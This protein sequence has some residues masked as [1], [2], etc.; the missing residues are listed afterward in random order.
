MRVLIEYQCPQCGAPAEL[1]E[2]DRLFSCQYC[3]VK[4]YLDHQNHFQYVLPDKAPTNKNLFFIPYWRF[5]GMLFSCINKNIE[6]KFVDVSLQAF[7]SI[8]FPVSVGL[9]SQSLKM[10]FVTPDLNGY[11][12]KP[13][14]TF[15]N[16]M[17]TFMNRFTTTPSEMIQHQTHVGETI[18]IIYSPFY[19]DNKLY[20]AVLNETIKTQLP[21]DFDI[22]NF[23]GG[24]PTWSLD[25]I[26]T[27][28]PYCGWDLKGDRDSIALI[29]NNCIS[30]WT[31]IKKKLK[32]INFGCLTIKDNAV[33]FPFWRIK[34]DISGI[35]LKS[36]ADLVKIANLPKAIQKGWDKIDFY[37]WVPGF[38]VRPKTFLRLL[39]QTT[40]AQPMDE[41]SDQLPPNKIFPVNLPS[42]EAAETLK[43]NLA[44]FIKNDTFLD[45]LS[46]IKIKPKDLLLTFIPFEEGHHDYVQPKYQISINK[47]QLILSSNL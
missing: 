17:D 4:S 35:L 37:F 9:R 24:K 7:D 28:C 13:K 6:H 42:E 23:P 19:A 43:I 41:L 21:D 40:T 31:P 29:C 30:V 8:L 25:L 16:V 27:L 1:E 10:K 12:V 22:Q 36:Y 45:N 5:K 20:D 46:Q 11:F 47:N 38:K 3:H 15:Q 14:L 32:Q 44:S 18:S 39:S 33:Y 34:A 2:T 26:P